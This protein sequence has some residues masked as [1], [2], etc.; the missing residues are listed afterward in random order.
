MSA[1]ALARRPLPPEPLELLPGSRFARILQ[2][3]H[4]AQRSLGDLRRAVCKPGRR[5]DDE[6]TRT[7][8]C[9]AAMAEAGL[10]HHDAAGFQAT[11]YALAEMARLGIPTTAPEEA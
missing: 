5:R 1:P 11:P 4:D 3:C 10:L 2:A 7:M 9:A 8:V 6:R